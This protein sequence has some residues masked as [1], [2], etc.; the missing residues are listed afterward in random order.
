[1][2][3]GSTK[4]TQDTASGAT[5]QA[6]A[7]TAWAGGLPL[8]QSQWLLFEQ[9]VHSLFSDE[10]TVLS[11]WND[12]ARA[13]SG[14]LAHSASSPSFE[15]R[16]DTDFVHT[17][18]HWHSQAL[19]C[20]RNHFTHPPRPESKCGANP[21]DSPLNRTSVVHQKWGHFHAYRKPALVS[22]PAVF[23][24]W[25]HYT[26]FNLT[27]RQHARL[28]RLHK[29]RTL[30]GVI[31]TA[32]QAA[33]RHDSYTLFACVRSLLPRVDRKLKLRTPSGQLMS[34][35]EEI[36]CFRQHIRTTW[37]GPARCPAYGYLMTMPFDQ[38]ALIQ[39][40]AHMPEIKAVALGCAP[41]AVWRLQAECVGRLL[42]R[43]LSHW[44]IGRYPFVPQSWKDGWLSF[45]PKPNKPPTHPSSLR[46]LA[47][48]D[49]LGKA[50]M[51]LVAEQIRSQAWSRLVPWPQ[52][53]YL[54]HR[55]TFDPISRVAQH[56]REARELRT[57]QR[58]TQH[59]RASG[60]I[61]PT[62]CGAVQVFLDV[63]KAF[64]N[65]PRESLVHGLVECGV[66]EGLATLIGEWHSGTRYHY[67]HLGIH[68]CEP[69]GKGVRQGCT[70]APILWAVLMARFLQRLAQSVP[71]AWIK[72]C[73]NIFA[74]D[75]QGGSTFRSDLELRAC[76]RYLGMVIDCLEDL[77]LTV[78]PVKT[79]AL[80]QLGG[81]QH[82]KWQALITKRGANGAYLLLPRKNGSMRVKLVSSVV[83]LGVRVSYAAFEQSTQSMRTSAAHSSAMSLSR[84][85]Y[86]KRRLPFRTR[87][88]LWQTCIIPC[89]EYG[90][91]AVGLTPKVIARHVTCLMKQLRIIT[92]NQSFHTRDSHLA[93]LHAF[94]LEHPIES[95]RR[96]AQAR[97]RQHDT[98]LLMLDAHDIVVSHSCYSIDASLQVI[99]RFREAL[100]SSSPSDLPA[101]PS[102]TGL[103][104]HICHALF[105]DVS[106]LHRHFT[107]VRAMF[108]CPQVVDYA[109]HAVEGLPE[110]THCLKKFDCWSTFRQHITQKRCYARPF[111]LAIESNAT[112]AIPAVLW[113]ELTSFCKY[114]DTETL[115]HAQSTL[116]DFFVA[117]PCTQAMNLSALRAR[118]AHFVH[119][120]HWHDLQ[121]DREAC[122]YLAHHCLRC[123]RWCTRSRDLIVHLR[124]AHPQILIPGIDQMIALQKNHVRSSPCPFCSLSWKQQHG[125]PIL[126]QAAI[127]QAELAT[128]APAVIVP[129]GLCPCLNLNRPSPGS[130]ICAPRAL[131]PGFN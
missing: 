101:L 96:S 17:L 124:E 6:P 54:P 75:L 89:A 21:S 16:P 73:L 12:E 47:L 22:L 57:S 128:S 119:G 69:S 30:D 93:V 9:E 105:T 13:G 55:S 125:C 37:Q 18:D 51:K 23:H 53:A 127:L 118:V 84:W 1:M 110:C 99:D 2:Q 35:V 8:W 82:R 98:D 122:D 64:D 63:D 116:D 71:T 67:T 111:A 36:A 19:Q 24:V 91:L 60:V 77:G 90:L 62:L 104:C 43:Q 40:L 56:C 59:D 106:D 14:C 83:Y 103:S 39:V 114:D 68:I 80:L 74:D 97:L 112:H 115:P 117:T 130:V 28:V 32:A 88:G 92:G 25:K 3:L 11:A 113:R 95:L 61:G 85:L 20:F 7:S 49:P 42:F 87:L 44:W 50:V 81:V 72:R 66:A 120:D 52:Y 48:T 26:N 33:A 10:P 58:P 4:D 126:L 31:E 129:G 70:G 79:V 38:A 102:Q 29:K 46:P 65:A 107:R 34:T 109:K 100:Y 108:S 86:S 41:G 15:A 131:E 27:H 5:D 123:G 94:G 78:N 45:I 121:Q 76:L